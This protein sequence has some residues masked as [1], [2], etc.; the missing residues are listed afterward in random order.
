MDF[1]LIEK[2]LAKFSGD[3]RSDNTKYGI[4]DTADIDSFDVAVEDAHFAAAHDIGFALSIRTPLRFAFVAKA[5]AAVSF[6]N[7]YKRL[8]D[9]LDTKLEVGIFDDVEQAKNWIFK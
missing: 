4:I 8:I 3:P 7:Q 9:R 5:P 6:F 1:D 2:A